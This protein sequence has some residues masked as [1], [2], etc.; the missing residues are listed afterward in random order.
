MPCRSLS[1]LPRGH[2][3][4]SST[5]PE[6]RTANLRCV[7]QLFTVLGPMP[8][9][10]S[11]L[12][13]GTT[14]HG[15]DCAEK[16]KGNG[17]ERRQERLGETVPQPDRGLQIRV[18]SACGSQGSACLTGI[19]KKYSG[20][21]VVGFDAS[22]LKVPQVRRCLGREKKWKRAELLAQTTPLLAGG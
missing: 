21:P 17:R 9:S 1:S 12:G 14:G 5:A 20:V 4:S 15:Q 7:V 8:S 18:R 2:Q 6:P 19:C 3:D 11:L 10:F 13:P 22:K 16:I